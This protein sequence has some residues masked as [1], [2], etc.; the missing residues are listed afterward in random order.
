MAA[1]VRTRD[2]LTAPAAARL[3][4]D[5]KTAV[6]NTL[7]EARRAAAESRVRAHDAKRLERL[8]RIQEQ[9]REL[10]AEEQ[11]G[12]MDGLRRREEK[13]NEERRQAVRK[14][15][16]RQERENRKLNPIAAQDGPV[17]S[18][19]PPPRKNPA[20]EHERRRLRHAA[21]REKMLDGFERR[22]AALQADRKDLADRH[23]R[24]NERRD[25]WQ[26][27]KREE[28]TRQQAQ[29]FEA[30]SRNEMQHAEN[31]LS[32]TFAR[33]RGDGRDLSR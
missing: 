22:A 20:A 30:R 12:A 6:P 2:E 10:D 27:Q 5:T 26:A 25:L 29:T 21:E 9:A 3:P 8:R 11:A 7:L 33:T 4:Q 23:A 18:M 16:E 19:G 15:E 13:L 31:A 24:H 32:R 17:F 1:R 14:L 28:L